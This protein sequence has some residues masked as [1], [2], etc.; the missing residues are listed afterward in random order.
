VYKSI[1]KIN[2]W[3]VKARKKCEASGGLLS[4]KEPPND[5]FPL[6]R[7]F[8]RVTERWLSMNLKKPFR[9]GLLN[10][11]FDVSG[12]LKVAERY[13]EHYASCFEQ[14][15]KN[16]RLKLFCIDP[17]DQLTDALQRCQAAVFFSATMTPVNYFKKI[18]GCDTSAGELSLPSPFPD[19]NLGIFVADRIST[20][21]RDRN[22][23]IHAISLTILSFVRQ[24]TGNYLLFFP[25]YE[26][27]MMIH[28][29]FEQNSPET[30]TI[31]QTYGMKEADRDAFL[32]RFVKQSPQTL[33][34][35]AVM[36]GIFG[37][38]ID[39]VGER[40]SGVVIVGVGLPGISPEREL[41][42][43]YFTV[44][45]RSGFEYAYLYPGI[46]RVLQA[47][48]RVIRSE[49]DR[50]TVLLIDQ[51]FSTFRYKSLLHR[52]WQPLTIQNEDHLKKELNKFWD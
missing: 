33:V 39:L 27:M 35:F 11:Y 30:E 3:L 20:L 6:L 45:N 2:S 22:R 25:S 16:L 24:K 50:G 1:G 7:N 38:G 13:N 10:L 36:G 49:K 48:G 34:G 26:Y 21:Y 51:R 5:L 37:E 19:R 29:S 18:L 15:K 17:S 28:G 42:R 41:I 44:Y 8:L 43:E 47:A 9:D 52:E 14:I 31:V 23:T 12:F 32:K 46:N 4:Q 40:L